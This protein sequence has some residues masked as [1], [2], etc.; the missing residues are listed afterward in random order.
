MVTGSPGA[1][2]T[3][4]P[5]PIDRKVFE[6]IMTAFELPRSYLDVIYRG[7]TTFLNIPSGQCAGTGRLQG[8]DRIHAEV[9]TGFC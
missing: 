1:S 6:Q 4:L 7:T 9:P 8:K 2:M 5:L 3:L